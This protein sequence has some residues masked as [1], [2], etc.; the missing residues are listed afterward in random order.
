M[1]FKLEDILDAT[2]T[3]L[4]VDPK[5]WHTMRRYR[6]ADVVKVKRYVS[7]VAF[8]FGYKYIEIGRF[9][10]NNRTTILYHVNTMSE[11]M[12]IYPD[13]GNTMAT[14]IAHLATREPRQREHVTY[15][16]LARTKKGILIESPS[17][18]ELVGSW[19]IAEGSRMYNPQD[20][21]PWITFETGPVRIRTE[22]TIDDYE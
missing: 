16:W 14:I 15:A 1:K 12:K 22:V 19:W 8:K 13:M 2:L 5:E 4:K 20:A 3:V 7:I 17:K 9:L 11:Q 18:P 10:G 6:N 21:F